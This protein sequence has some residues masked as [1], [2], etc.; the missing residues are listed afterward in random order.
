TSQTMHK[1]EKAVARFNHKMILWIIREPNPFYDTNYVKTYSKVFT[2]GASVSSKRLKMEFK[3]KSSG[4]ILQ[5]NP[6]I[7]YSPGVFV[8]TSLV[9]F[10]I[11]P[12]FAGIH[13]NSVKK[14]TS[15]FNDYQFNIFTR[16]FLF[17]ISLQLYSGFYLS[18]TRSY[19]EYAFDEMKENYYKRPDLDAISGNFNIFYVFNNRK[20]SSRAPFSFTQSQVKSAG[21]CI[22]GT[23]LSD[24]AFTADSSVVGSQIQGLFSTFPFMKS[25]NSFST[26]LSFGYAYTF[27]AKKKFYV[28][29]A[30]IPGLGFNK[31]SLE[32]TDYTTLTGD[33]EI[34]AKLKSTFGIGYN[35]SKWFWGCMFISDNYFSSSASVPMEVQYQISKFRFFAGRR[36]NA[37]KVEDTILKKAGI[38][39]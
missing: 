11:M 13:E 39:L 33:N 32:R 18:N 36:F 22:I 27:V 25:G 9:G 1:T 23:Y 7:I 6:A 8:N 30:L 5:Y 3:E 31:L 20:F 16:R 24:F 26:G 14:G 28:S 15:D 2:L 12:G 10:S 19:K 34:S 38:H 37:K 35:N 29:I 17:D 4:R 21:S